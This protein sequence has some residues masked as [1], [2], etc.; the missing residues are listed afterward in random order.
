VSSSSFFLG[1][2]RNPSTPM[3]WNEINILFCLMWKWWFSSMILYVVHHAIFSIRD[4]EGNHHW[5]WVEVHG[6]KVIESA[7]F[8]H[9]STRGTRYKSLN[10]VMGRPS[11]TGLSRHARTKV[12]VMRGGETMLLG[13]YLLG[14]SSVHTCIKRI[15]NHNQL[16]NHASGKSATPQECFTPLSFKYFI[17]FAQSLFS[18]QLHLLLP[19]YLSITLVYLS[20]VKNIS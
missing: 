15:W 9:A 19:Y 4:I 17:A 14:L 20:K 11:I 7:S 1:R 13:A 12:V 5:A 3:I 2:W 16:S 8:N 6:H 10:I 18:W